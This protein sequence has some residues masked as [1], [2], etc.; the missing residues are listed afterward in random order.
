MKAYIY[1]LLFICLLATACSKKILPVKATDVTVEQDSTATTLKE[2]YKDTVI[3][4]PGGAASI[5]GKLQL[6]T[7]TDSML[8]KTPVFQPIAEISKQGIVTAKLTVDSKG[9]I[10]VNCEADSLRHVLT[11]LYSRHLELWIQKNKTQKVEV[12]VPYEVIKYKPPDWIWY[13]IAYAI[14][15]TI[16]TFRKP[17]YN[18]V[19]HR[20]T[21]WK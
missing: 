7:T 1:L 16:I 2:V 11:Q 21:Q 19:K 8:I 18:F 3:T 6:A 9:N 15:I 10:N 20:L 13:V 5:S 14:L 12:P 17:I 4:I